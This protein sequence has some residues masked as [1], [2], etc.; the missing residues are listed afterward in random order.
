MQITSR[1]APL[2]QNPFGQRDR[3]RRFDVV[4]GA[5]GDS[6]LLFESFENRFRKLAVEGAVDDDFARRRRSNRRPRQ[7]GRPRDPTAP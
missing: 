3:F 7:R 6:G 1:P 2:A 5:D 4:A